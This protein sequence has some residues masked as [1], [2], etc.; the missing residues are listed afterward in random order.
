MG[1]RGGWGLEVRV[2]G[3]VVHAVRGTAGEAFGGGEAL[4]AAH[5]DSSWRLDSLLF[6]FVTEDVV[7]R[8]VLSKAYVDIG[9]GHVM[10][11]CLVFN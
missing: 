1:L 4:Y 7:G 8:V 3:G 11:A 2:D 10:S 9:P 5:L 6:L